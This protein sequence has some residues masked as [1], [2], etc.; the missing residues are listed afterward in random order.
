MHLRRVAG[1]ILLV[2]CLIGT[3]GCYSFYLLST[4]LPSEADQGDPELIVRVTTLDGEKVVLKKPWLGE[5][6]VGGEK[7]KV[8]AEPRQV[9]IP[10]S[11]VDR[12]EERE[13]DRERTLKAVVIVLGLLGV[14]AACGTGGC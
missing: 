9:L 13:F 12:I 5:G 11:Q 3:P 10:L 14:G 6:A 7:S 2:G 1:R 4:H 8:M